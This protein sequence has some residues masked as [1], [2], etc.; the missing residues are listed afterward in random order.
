MAVTRTP[1]TK[2][3]RIKADLVV[4]SLDVL[5]ARLAYDLVFALYHRLGFEWFH[6]SQIAILIIATAKQASHIPNFS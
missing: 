2:G 6:I 4:R 3:M 1:H 5:R